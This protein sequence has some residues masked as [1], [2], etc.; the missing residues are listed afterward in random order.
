ML[1]F[2]RQGDV[3]GCLLE[4]PTQKLIAMAP[5]SPRHLLQI[6]QGLLIDESTNEEC[7]KLFET[8]MMAMKVACPADPSDFMMPTS[9]IALNVNQFP[10]ATHVDVS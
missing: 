6:S 8:G 10:Y 3:R 1:F 5:L 4:S 9:L 7:Q 2:S